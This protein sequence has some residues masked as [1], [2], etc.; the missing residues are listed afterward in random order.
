MVKRIHLRI[1]A[2]PSINHDDAHAVEK[3]ARF[4][5]GYGIGYDITP[6]SRENLRPVRYSSFMNDVLSH[7]DM[8]LISDLATGRILDTLREALST[9]DM[10]GIG[11]TAQ[12]LFSREG[13]KKRELLGAGLFA[14][15]AF[16]STRSIITP[17]GYRHSPLSRDKI[18]EALAKHEMG[19]VLM[20]RDGHCQ[21]DGCI[22]RSNSK[23][24]ERFLDMVAKN[25]GFC[26]PCQVAISKGILMLESG[27]IW[28]GSGILDGV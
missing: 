14:S 6:L 9:R 13:I 1:L 28:R 17:Q 3:A 10:I 20:D 26:N 27:A 18:I 25:L 16:L 11:I 19:H 23:S 24:I 4:F 7:P 21:N 8:H 5:K 22:M 15:C 12:S 2:S